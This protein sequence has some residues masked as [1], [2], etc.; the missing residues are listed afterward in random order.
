[1]P[2]E[3]VERRLA[4]IMVAD[5]VGYS[6]LIRIDEEGTRAAFRQHNKE[7]IEPHIAAHHGRIFKT[8]G[9]G[10]LAEF[11]SVV[12]AVRCA[13]GIQS[14]IRA[15][16]GDV[17]AEKRV[18]FRIGV[19][20]GDVIAEGDD[21][22]GDG[23]NVAAR[24]EGLAKP[25][26]ICISGSAFEQ[27]RDK[28]E[29]GFEDLGD[30][31]VKNIDRPVRVYRILTDPGDIG[32]IVNAPTGNAAGWRKPAIAAALVA[33]IA[34]GWLGWQQPW[35]TTV[36]APAPEG[37][38][39][40]ILVLPFVNATGD[41]GQDYIA[42]GLT[43]SVTSDLS[44]IRDAFVV[45]AT[46]AYTYKNK[47]VDLKQL[48]EDQDVRFVLQGSVQKGGDTIRINTQL[49]DTQTNAQLWAETFE[50]DPTDLF[51]LQ[52]QVTARI[53]NSIGRQMV[54]MAARE[55]ETRVTNPQAAD[56]ILRAAAAYLKPQ[57]L[58]N[59]EKIERWYRHTLELDPE[60]TT[61]MIGLARALTV[62]AFNFG[63]LLTADAR[64]Q[65]FAEGRDW[66]LKVKELDPF[67]PLIYGSLALYYATHNDFPSQRRVSETWL[68]LDPKNPMA[69]NFM[70]NVEIYLG[71]YSEAIELLNQGTAL[72]PK[73]PN[74]LL[75]VSYFRA[76][77]LQGDNDSAIEWGQRALELN[78]KFS[79]A[80]V[81]LA[82]AYA[83]K[84][85]DSKARVAVENLLRL[86]PN[87]KLTRFRAPQSSRPA[88]HNDA[89]SELILPAGRKAGL[90]E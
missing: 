29:I 87:F 60:N 16:N 14:D 31:Q 40:S 90:P 68:S 47:S 71:N 37:P 74:V 58:E 43:A 83:L 53:G 67:N 10:F 63:Q 8:V 26:G 5:V 18:E 21:L 84:G 1:M 41:P 2:E 64:E 44:R 79:E 66:A 39:V 56:L 78:P 32:K 89:Y 55:N 36:E 86:D 52:D 77:F 49:A 33:I 54:I 28:L 65:K 24:L 80:Y 13:V 57:S 3:R 25:Q 50:G 22:H 88:A 61:A 45:A 73:H 46:T 34:V 59:W 51:A 48:G 7:T 69:Y 85:D 12:D 20:L 19:N 62:Q 15:R 30:Q 76:Y 6:A 11:A 27:V 38:A 23:V 82:M 72:D 4:A 42:D 70:A 75:A 35:A 9:D 17:A 81:F